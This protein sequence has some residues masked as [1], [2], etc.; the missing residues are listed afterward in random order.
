[1][2]GV[3]YPDAIAFSPDGQYLLS[4]N[5]G[6]QAL[7]GGRGFSIWALNGELVWDDGG[8]IEQRAVKAGLYPDKR[9]DKR[10]IEVEGITAARFGSRDFAFAVSERG[11]FL[12]IYD[13][14]NPYAPEFVQ[15]L[16]TGDGPESVVALPSRN[17]VL[18]AAEESGT[19][20]V[21]QFAS[22]DPAANETDGL[23]G[24]PELIK[25]TL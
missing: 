11:S 5:E 23:F 1:M 12:V 2:A 13:I 10:G 9:S 24:L 17:L 7:T 4:A 15:I 8:E 19:I 3:R 25:E 21:F 16:P 22:G 18:V 14:S 20:T 6:E